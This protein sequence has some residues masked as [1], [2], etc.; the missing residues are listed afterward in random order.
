MPSLNYLEQIQSSINCRGDSAKIDPN[1]IGTK[2]GILIE[3][4]SFFYKSRFTN[5]LQ[6]SHKKVE[7]YEVSLKKGSDIKMN[8]K[9]HRIKY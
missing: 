4:I 9:I 5:Y 3:I 7:C 6:I 2:C 1:R 8:H